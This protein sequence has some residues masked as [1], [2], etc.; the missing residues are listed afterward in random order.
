MK[1][2][3][4]FLILFLLCCIG[5]SAHSQQATDTRLGTLPELSLHRGHTV[6]ILSPEPI[7]YV[8]IA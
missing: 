4:H 5:Y 8:D 6:H 1:K 7:Q 2:K 3:H